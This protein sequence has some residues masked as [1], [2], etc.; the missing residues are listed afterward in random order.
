MPGGASPERSL[1][2]LRDSKVELGQDTS[3]QAFDGSEPEEFQ[4]WKVNAI[5]VARMKQ[6]SLS[7]RMERPK[8]LQGGSDE[9]K[10]VRKAIQAQWNLA[11]DQL[12]G[13]LACYTSGV[14][15]AIVRPF[16][17]AGDGR[18]GLQALVD[19]DERAADGRSTAMVA[20]RGP[21]RG[22]TRRNGRGGGGRGGGHAHPTG[23]GGG[24][25]GNG[26]ECWRCGEIGHFR[27]DC[28][29]SSKGPAQ[30]SAR[31]AVSL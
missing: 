20:G 29:S 10:A 18:A 3:V 15:A 17:E 16:V 8:D 28:R 14:A 25:A 30:G 5:G 11:D 4:R 27:R 24:E 6:F 13:V 19:E 22:A 9:E 2:G 12:V 23:R 1:R 21:T 31:P 7:I 26:Q